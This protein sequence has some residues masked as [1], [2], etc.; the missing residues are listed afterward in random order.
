[1]FLAGQ[2]AKHVRNRLDPP[3]S[4]YI[5]SAV[6]DSRLALL[7]AVATAMAARYFSL[8]RF[9]SFLYFKVACIVLYHSHRIAMR[10]GGYGWNRLADRQ[11]SPLPFACADRSSCWHCS[12]VASRPAIPLDAVQ[13]SPFIGQEVISF[14]VTHCP[15]IRR[16]R[17]VSQLEPNTIMFQ[18][19]DE[20]YQY[21]Y[22][23]H[24]EQKRTD[25]RFIE[26]NPYHEPLTL[27]N[28]TIKFIRANMDAHPIYLYKEQPEVEEAGFKLRAVTIDTLQFFK[29]EK[30]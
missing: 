30:P 28:S 3:L 19:W 6:A 17:V 21:W 11:D 13:G 4:G 14:K 22:A 1:L 15:N 12:P 25:L 29:V 8:W 10:R 20:L 24:F 9:G 7:G 26:Q 5:S 18:S 16:F 2:W 27:A 23:A